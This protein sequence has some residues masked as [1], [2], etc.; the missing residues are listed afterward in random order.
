VE[1]DMGKA[2]SMSVLVVDDEAGIASLLSD[3]LEAEGYRVVTASNGVAALA[4]LEKE[5]VDAVLTDIRMPELDGPALY[6]EIEQRYPALVPRVAFMTGNILDEDTADF[7]AAT[8]APCIRKPFLR[9][10]VLRVLQQVLA[11]R[12]ARPLAVG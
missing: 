8:G 2:S 5:R 4:R 6:R 10:D 12:N 7:F 9:D 1:V 11:H 3:V